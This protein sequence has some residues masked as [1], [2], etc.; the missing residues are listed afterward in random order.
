MQNDAKLYFSKLYD[1]I[2]L[3]N[4][5]ILPLNEVLINTIVEERKLEKRRDATILYYIIISTIL[6]L[7]A[8]FPLLIYN[9]YL[10]IVNWQNHLSLYL[11]QSNIHNNHPELELS[12]LILIIAIPCYTLIFPSKVFIN[13]KDTLIGL[14]HKKSS[15]HDQMLDIIKNSPT[16]ILFTIILNYIAIFL[17]VV[18]LYNKHLLSIHIMDLM[19][20]VLLMIPTS[21]IALLPTIILSII[22]IVISVKKLPKNASPTLMIYYLTDLI[23]TLDNIEGISVLTNESRSEVVRSILKVSELMGRMYREIAYTDEISNWSVNEMSLASKNFKSLAGWIYFPQENS[24][25]NLRERLCKY[26]N[27]FITGNYHELP[28]GEI[29]NI[30]FIFSN[31]SLIKKLI[32]FTLFGVF[33][34]FPIVILII[35]LNYTKLNLTPIIK[36]LGILYIVWVIIGLFLFSDILS[37]DVIAFIKEIIKSIIG[38]K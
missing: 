32:T 24:L 20:L 4:S 34:A 17:L 38:K 21:F 2:K 10:I 9:M 6:F 26:L 33:V 8:T 25:D 7:I 31:K 12:F 11:Y 16:Y 13:A 28:R 29:N 3:K 18:E 22:L 37:P 1:S 36:P 35:A 15:R 14:L 5:S 23:D 30:N 19:I 27:I